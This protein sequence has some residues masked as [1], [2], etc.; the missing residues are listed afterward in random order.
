MA[1][2]QCLVLVSGT[3]NIKH[4]PL[5]KGRTPESVFLPI[6]KS[7]LYFIKK[8]NCLR[9]FTWNGIPQILRFSGGRDV[10]STEEKLRPGCLFW[11][12]NKLSIGNFRTA[13]PTKHTLSKT[14]FRLKRVGN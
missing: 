5:K 6:E 9:Y 12:K 8:S 10:F 11:I 3:S 7:F 13:M 14:L 4:W 1:A 2:G